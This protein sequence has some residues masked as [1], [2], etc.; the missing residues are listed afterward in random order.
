MGER[1]G[2]E[3]ER[4]SREKGRN[5]RK[6]YLL[7]KRGTVGGGYAEGK[8]EGG[9]Y[10]KKRRMKFERDRKEERESKSFIHS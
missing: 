6:V 4:W 3:G 5:E 9:T 2:R 10:T 1:G 7:D 8:R